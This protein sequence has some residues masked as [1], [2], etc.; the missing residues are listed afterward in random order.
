MSNNISN[1][2]YTLKEGGRCEKTKQ[3]TTNTLVFN[4][5]LDL[6]FPGV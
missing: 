6:V 2:D 1:A 4:N 5:L 3:S